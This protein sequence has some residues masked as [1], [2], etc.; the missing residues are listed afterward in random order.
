MCANSISASGCV[1]KFRCMRI[2]PEIRPREIRSVLEFT[3]N[4]CRSR[5]SHSN[6]ALGSFMRAYSSRGEIV[7]ISLAIE[8]N[9][10]SGVFPFPICCLRKSKRRLHSSRKSYSAFASFQELHRR[11]KIQALP[12]KYLYI[13]DGYAFTISRISCL[14]QSGFEGEL[15]SI[16]RQTLV[17]ICRPRLAARIR[18]CTGARWIAETLNF[19]DILR[20]RHRCC[21][22]T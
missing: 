4:M 12:F 18:T 10:E 2:F 5:L 11:C 19:L 13:P 20:R 6:S 8:G 3:K 9:L 1:H 7:N 22:N 14:H 15:A 21:L 16:W 17:I